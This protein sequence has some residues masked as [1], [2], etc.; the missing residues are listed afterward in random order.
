MNATLKFSANE[1]FNEKAKLNSQLAFNK[2]EIERLLQTV[3]EAV[4][5]ESEERQKIHAQTIR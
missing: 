2:G 5:K 3:S 4:K 1:A